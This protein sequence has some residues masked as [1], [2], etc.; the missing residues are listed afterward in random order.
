MNVRS[1]Q[2]PA[3]K[4][5]ILLWPPSLKHCFLEQFCLSSLGILEGW[6]FFCSFG[7]CLSFS[8]LLNLFLTV[9]GL[10]KVIIQ[11]LVNKSII[12]IKANEPNLILITPQS[13]QSPFFSYANIAEWAQFL[14]KW[15]TKSSSLE[16]YLSSFI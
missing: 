9:P 13:A 3:E 15:S 7:F 12:G 16:S 8:V 6:V 14:S 10:L 5:E 2:S 4:Q 1:C 11:Y